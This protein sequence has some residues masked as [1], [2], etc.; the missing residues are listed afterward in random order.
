MAPRVQ[1]RDVSE[2][3]VE[4]GS[5]ADDLS[6][7]SNWTCTGET[8]SEKLMHLMKK[9]SDIRDS[10]IILSFEP[11]VA[12]KYVVV[13]RIS[14]GDRCGIVLRSSFDVQ[15][16]SSWFPQKLVF[17]LALTPFFL[18]KVEELSFELD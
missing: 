4:D 2:L 10:E 15:S 13:D 16:L 3:K 11:M 12:Y 6:L 5:A 18:A 17:V 14:D 9:R 7:V 8:T 1:V